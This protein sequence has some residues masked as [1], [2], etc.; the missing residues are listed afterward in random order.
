MASRTEPKQ[1]ETHIHSS[2]ETG[3]SSISTLIVGSKVCTLI[4]PPF[5]IPDANS[6]VAWI[7]KITSLPLKAVF[8]THHHPDHYF[9][10]NPILDAF[11]TATLYA[12]PYVC[13]GINREYD[14]KVK[15]WPTIYGKENVPENPTKPTPF[16]FSFYVMEGDETS[17]V[18]LLG[19]LQGD[20]VDHCLFW[21][22]RERTIICGDA[23]YARSTHVW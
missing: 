11:P 10:A 5:L 1:L 18:C 14:E 13:A 3:L 12:A 21:L 9:S 19:P 20:S 23:V 17:P 15:F 2:S 4:D 22:P 8:I 6:V 16:N 7:K